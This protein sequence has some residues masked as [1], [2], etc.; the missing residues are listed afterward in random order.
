MSPGGERL[1][2]CSGSNS[3]GADPAAAERTRAAAPPGPAVLAMALLLQ[4]QP[5]LEAN[6]DGRSGCAPVSENQS[7]QIKEEFGLKGPS[8]FV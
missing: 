6:G 2:G 4:H 1:R 7:Q 5:N 3:P 8:K